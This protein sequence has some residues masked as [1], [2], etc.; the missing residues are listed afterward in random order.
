MTIESK[1][2]IGRLAGHV[3]SNNNN[4]KTRAVVGMKETLGPLTLTVAYS[5]TRERKRVLKIFYN[6]GDTFGHMH[7]QNTS[8]TVFTLKIDCS[9]LQK[10][11]TI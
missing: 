9:F 11:D 2:T 8:F 4:K 1:M 3:D 6:Y 10:R 5:H 7:Y